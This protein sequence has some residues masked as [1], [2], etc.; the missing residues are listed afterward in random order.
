MKSVCEDEGY[1]G[2]DEA[3]EEQV[4]EESQSD[5]DYNK[6]SGGALFEEDWR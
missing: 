5:C 4:C 2:Y 1:G 3:I 6:G